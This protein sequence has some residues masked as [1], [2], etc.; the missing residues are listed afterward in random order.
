M[1]FCAFLYMNL[2][3][4]C[5]SPSPAKQVFLFSGG[6]IKSVFGVR[7]G[8]VERCVLDPG[9]VIDLKTTA[10]GDSR[11]H[12]LVIPMSKMWQFWS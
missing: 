1:I 6:S 3:K 8:A 7:A 9:S 5:F 11:W 2:R 12:S 10:M 4:T